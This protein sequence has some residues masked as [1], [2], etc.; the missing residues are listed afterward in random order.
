M[1]SNRATQQGV[2]VPT[3]TV[4]TANSMHCRPLL[5]HQ[6]GER[7]HRFIDEKFDTPQG[8]GP[9][10]AR[11]ALYQEPACSKPGCDNSPHGGFWLAWDFRN[12]ALNIGVVVS[13]TT[14]DTMIEAEKRDYEPGGIVSAIS[15]RL[16]SVLSQYSTPRRTGTVVTGRQPGVPAPQLSTSRKSKPERASIFL[17]KKSAF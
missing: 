14:S 7:G 4:W 15:E 6:S 13:E 9:T 10:C 8:H 16:S 3:R 5:Q 17:T 2:S 12:L 11:S 1:S